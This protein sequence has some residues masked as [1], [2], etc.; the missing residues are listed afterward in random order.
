MHYPICPYRIATLTASNCANS[1]AASSLYAWMPLLFD[2]SVLLL[3]LTK[4]VA[5]VRGGN[6][7]GILHTFFRDGIM[8]YGCVCVRVFDTEVMY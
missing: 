4:T 5:A 2:T 1:G 7:G 3:T 8:Y 6:A